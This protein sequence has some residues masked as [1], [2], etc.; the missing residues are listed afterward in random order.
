[1]FSVSFNKYLNSSPKRALGQKKKKKKKKE[2]ALSKR[3]LVSMRLGQKC[4]ILA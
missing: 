4:I 2:K 3:N 1:M